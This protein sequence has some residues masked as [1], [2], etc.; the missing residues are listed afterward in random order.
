MIGYMHDFTVEQHGND[1]TIKMNADDRQVNGDHY[2]KMAVQ[3]WELMEEVMTKSEFVG[4]LKGNMIKYALRAGHK[5]GS[6][7]AA[8]YEHYKQKLHEYLAS[9]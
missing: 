2:K 1:F 6:D 9:Y 8:K 7:D 3:P 4:Y 5:P